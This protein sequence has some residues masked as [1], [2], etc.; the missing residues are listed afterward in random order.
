MSD[1]FVGLSKIKLV[2]TR[3]ISQEER[4]ELRRIKNLKG[5]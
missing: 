3:I 5:L 4:K 1:H 2:E